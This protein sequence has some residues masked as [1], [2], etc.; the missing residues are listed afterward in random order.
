MTTTNPTVSLDLSDVVRVSGFAKVQEMLTQVLSH[1]KPEPVNLYNLAVL[2]EKFADGLKMEALNTIL[3]FLSGNRGRKVEQEPAKVETVQ[4][5][6]QQVR[7]PFVVWLHNDDK[8]TPEY[9][10]RM[11]R[12]IL[13]KE[14]GWDGWPFAMKVHD[15]GTGG[16]VPF[17]YGSRKACRAI[18]NRIAAFGTD[19]LADSVLR[20]VSGPMKAT[21]SRKAV[22]R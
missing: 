11:A 4:Q 8:H 20:T 7:P 10:I 12:E 1:N 14:A 6:P 15:S 18:R 17:F 5:S 22:V 2:I 16:K 13:G 9:V 21:V 3:D 19:T